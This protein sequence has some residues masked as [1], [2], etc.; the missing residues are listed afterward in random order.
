M[1]AAP[2]AVLE[3]AGEGFELRFERRGPSR[4]AS[5]RRT[6]ALPTTTASTCAAQFRDVLGLRDAEPDRERQDR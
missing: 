6:N 1:R 2:E 3:L 4:F 5:I